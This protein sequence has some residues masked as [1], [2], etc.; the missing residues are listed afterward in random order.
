MNEQQIIKAFEGRW[1]IKGKYVD[2]GILLGENMSEAIK[3]LCLDFFRAG[4]DLAA[5]PVT[6][7]VGSPGVEECPAVPPQEATFDEWWNL[8][9]KKRSRDKCEKK[10]QKLTMQ[11]RIDCI[12][13]TP[14]YVAST[15]DKKYRKDPITYLNNH[16][17]NDEI[18][19]PDSNRAQA[20]QR[21]ASVASLIASYAETHQ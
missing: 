19:I 3:S 21:A 14:A 5:P 20:A 9:D 11:D 7:P 18:I 17:W 2:Q 15:P 16:S 8:Y 4:L 1:R 10:W 6:V 12:A 13:A